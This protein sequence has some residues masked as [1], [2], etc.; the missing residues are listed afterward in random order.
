MGLGFGFAAPGRQWRHIAKEARRQPEHR[1][2]SSR[3]LS[4]LAAV[5]LRTIFGVLRDILVGRN[6]LDRHDLFARARLEAVSYTH[7][8]LPTILRV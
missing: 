3:G 8:T 1:L 2:S 6:A 7:L 4:A 5:T